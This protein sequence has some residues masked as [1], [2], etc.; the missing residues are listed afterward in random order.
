MPSTRS[1]APAQHACARARARAARAP[2][3]S[4]RARAT[5]RVSTTRARYAASSSARGSGRRK[6]AGGPRW[7]RQKPAG[8][9]APGSPQSQQ[10]PATERYMRK[11]CRR[12]GPF[13][14]H[15]WQMAEHG[16]M[17]QVRQRY[18]MY[19]L[20]QMR[21]HT[22]ERA[23]KASCTRRTYSSPV[24]GRAAAAGGGAGG[25]GEGRSGEGAGRRAA[26]GAGRGG[27]RWERVPGARLRATGVRCVTGCTGC[28]AHESG[29]E[30]NG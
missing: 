10:P 19:P 29:R 6:A 30:R 28:P 7:W 26:E 4:G 18:A 22:L 23:P 21:P 1:G 9:Q 16:L 17:P 20:A 25:W 11:L 8:R 27:A 5:W 15:S 13:S 3:W 12:W 2:E 14:K 24:C